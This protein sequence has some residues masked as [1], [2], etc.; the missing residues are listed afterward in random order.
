MKESIVSGR[1]KHFS[2]L[3][4]KGEVNEGEYCEWKVETLFRFERQN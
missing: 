4:G 2:G 3:K 1:L